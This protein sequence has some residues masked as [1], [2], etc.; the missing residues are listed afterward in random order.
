M[1][2]DLRPSN[3]LYANDSASPDTLIICNF[4]LAKKISMGNN[5]MRTA[6]SVTFDIQK[7]RAEIFDKAEDIWSLGVLLY[8]LLTGLVLSFH[9]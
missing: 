8:I 5:L 7:R 4:G 2:K 3:F 9:K 6:D 1:H